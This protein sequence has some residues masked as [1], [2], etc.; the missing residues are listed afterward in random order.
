VNFFENP[1]AVLREV[2]ARRQSLLG[3]THPQTLE[4]GFQL[5]QVYFKTDRHDAALSVHGSVYG[6]RK[7]LFGP[8]SPQTIQSAEVYGQ[9][10]MCRESTNAQIQD[11]WTLLH[12]TLDVKKD[13]LGIN[14]E[15]VTSALRLATISAI[16]GKFAESAE[17]FAWIFEVRADGLDL[18]GTPGFLPGKLAAGLAAAGM[19]FLDRNDPKGNR[20]LRRVSDLTGE[21]YGTGSQAT[22]TFVYVQAGALFLQRKEDKCRSILRRAFET[23]KVSFGR[24]HPQTKAAGIILAMEIF[25]DTLLSKSRVDEELDEINDWLLEFAPDEEKWTFVMRFCQTGAVIATTLK[26]ENLSKAMLSWL[27]RTQKRRNGL[28]NR[29]TLGTLVLSHS[30]RLYT[31][32]RRKSKKVPTAEGLRRDP[33]IFTPDLW[34][35]FVHTMANRLA[36]FSQMPFVAE[37]LANFLRHSPMWKSVE[38]T[39]FSAQFVS[40]FVPVYEDLAPPDTWEGKEGRRYMADYFV[41]RRPSRTLPLRLRMRVLCM[42]NCYYTLRYSSAATQV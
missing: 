3:E 19:A 28:F 1:Q 6:S 20:L 5:G 34:P 23:R 40:L 31:M 21:I 37:T 33:R 14:L 39:Q 38:A 27:Y 16:S 24:R 11:G 7:D 15:T 4:S 25:I 35:A 10:L 18:S 29:S 41:S 32:Y 13:M 22:Q 9:V 30:L 8:Q 26:L 17:V 42:V 36:R 12:Q 2:W